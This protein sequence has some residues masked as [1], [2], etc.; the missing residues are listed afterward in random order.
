[1]FGA[2]LTI[3]GRRR[4]SATTRT[5]RRP[6]STASSTTAGRRATTAGSAATT[7]A[8]ST[9]R[10]TRS[11]RCAGRCAPGGAR[12]GR[13]RTS[14]TSLLDAGRA[15]GHAACATSTPTGTRA[16]GRAPAT[17][18]SAAG[19]FETPRL[20]L[21]SGLGN[22]PDLV[23][24]YLMYHFQTFVRRRLPVPAA[25]PPGPGGHPPHGRPDRRP[26][27]RARRRPRRR[28]CPGSA[29]GSSSTAAPA[30]PIMEAVHLPAGRAHT[31][32]MLRLA[33]ARPAV[34]CSR[35]RAR[36][37]R[38]RR[39]RIDLDPHGP[40]RLGLPRRP[41]HLRAPPPRGRVRAE[42]WAPRLEAVMRRGRRRA[43]RSG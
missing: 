43:T 41:G 31:R 38:R 32:L 37:S 34:R 30:S 9:P 22:S 40:R 1:M 11:R 24:R 12:S 3:G 29:A 23:G 36:T 39:N 16:R 5:G 25:R 35:C 15:P 42:H 26:T 13:R 8:R 7:A 14:P 18:C 6:A 17:W 19:A 27:P 33:D 28:A 10:A 20:L 4:G 21:R 2:V